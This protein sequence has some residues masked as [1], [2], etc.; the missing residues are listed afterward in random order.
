MTNPSTALAISS[1]L[2][3]GAAAAAK[4]QSTASDIEQN[5]KPRRPN[6]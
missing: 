4:S 5:I 1:K 2:Q 6:A 3:F